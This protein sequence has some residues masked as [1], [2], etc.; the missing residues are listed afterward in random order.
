MAIAIR[1]G[2]G[3]VGAG[4]THAR[5][6]GAGFLVVAVQWRSLAGTIHYVEGVVVGAGVPVV[7]GAEI[8]ER[9]EGT[10]IRCVADAIAVRVGDGYGHAAGASAV[11]ERAGIISRI[12][13]GGEAEAFAIDRDMIAHGAGPAIIA[14]I[15]GDTRMKGAIVQCVTDPIPIG[16]GYGRVLATCY[17]I[18]AIE[19]AVI[20]VEAV[21][22]YTRATAEAIDGIV[23]GACAAII[24]RGSNGTRDEGAGVQTEAIAI[25]VGYGRVVTTA[26]GIAEVIGAGVRIVAEGTDLR[27][28][29]RIAEA[30]T[31]RIGYGDMYASPGRKAS[32]D[33]AGIQIITDHRD[34]PA[35]AA[36]AD[37]IE[38]G[39]RIAIIAH[40]AYDTRMQRTVVD[41]IANAIAVHI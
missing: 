19:R 40:G 32:I 39:A 17:R 14:G 20:A 22:R 1:I 2:H 11:A 30:V 37:R 31:I 33:S 18:A 29:Q 28:F 9:L 24:A 26:I 36:C 12:A 4:A 15:T 35:L 16:I 7:A 38:V 6:D 41:N 34:P 25:R 5:I 13:G 27:I 10:Y 8:T 3:G 23:G 21:D